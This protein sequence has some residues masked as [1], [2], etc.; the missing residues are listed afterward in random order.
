MATIAGR[1]TF[2]NNIRRSQTSTLIHELLHVARKERTFSHKKLAQAMFKVSLALEG[3][4]PVFTKPDGTDFSKPKDND[5]GANRDY[6]NAW[7]RR[8]CPNPP[9]ETE[10]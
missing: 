8:Y 5:D 9:V 4:T 3:A 2:R 10:E 1:V 7:I 6:M